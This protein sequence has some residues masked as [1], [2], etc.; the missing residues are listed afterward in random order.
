M[1]GVQGGNGQIIIATANHP[2]R[3]D[4]AFLRPGRI[5]YKIELTNGSKEQARAMFVRFHGEEGADEFADSIVGGQFSMAE[6]QQQVMILG[7]WR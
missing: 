5:D 3:L 4:P 7:D 2:E 6:L 1:D